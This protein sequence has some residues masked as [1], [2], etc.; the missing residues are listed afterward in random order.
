[1]EINW[2][3]P[4]FLQSPLGISSGLGPKKFPARPLHAK[5]RHRAQ[6]WPTSYQWIVE[7]NTLAHL[8]RILPTRPLLVMWRLSTKRGTQMW[9]TRQRHSKLRQ[10]SVAARIQVPLS[11][12]WTVKTSISLT[13]IKDCK[14]KIK[15]LYNYPIIYLHI[16]RGNATALPCTKQFS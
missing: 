14:F 4:I 15:K 9:P 3:T 10:S 2:L 13:Y 1:M 7:L 12:M 5:L 6:A 11:W 8:C 16:E